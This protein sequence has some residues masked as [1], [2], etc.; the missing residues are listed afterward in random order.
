M[1]LFLLKKK[2]PGPYD[3]FDA[4]LIRAKDPQKARNIANNIHADEGPIWEDPKLSSCR[5][6]KEE[7]GPK[8]I[9]SSFNAG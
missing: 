6:V 4:F 1:G 7:G 3:S 2:K 8:I 9:I 5:I